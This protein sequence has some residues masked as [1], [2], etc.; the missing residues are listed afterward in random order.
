[1]TVD[2]LQPGFGPIDGAHDRPHGLAWAG[3]AQSRQD[4]SASK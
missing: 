3:D 4:E 1:M 2:V